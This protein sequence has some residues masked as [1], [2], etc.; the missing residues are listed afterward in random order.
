M[1]DS[2]CLPHYAEFAA[3]F[4]ELVQAVPN[5]TVV[6]ADMLASSLSNVESLERA[7]LEKAFEILSLKVCPTVV[8][9]VL[10]SWLHRSDD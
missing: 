2:K 8:A 6:T 10:I 4:H 5:N 7:T 3:S 9:F 1:V